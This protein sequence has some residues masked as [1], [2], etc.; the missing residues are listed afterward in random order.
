MLDCQNKTL[1]LI[2]FEFCFRVDELYKFLQLWVPHLYGELCPDEVKA[3]G[4]ELVES[5][6]ELWDDD[7][8]TAHEGRHPSQDGEISELTRE[9]W[10]VKIN[11]I[12]LHHS[13]QFT[14]SPD[15]IYI[16]SFILF[17]LSLECSVMI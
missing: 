8:S 3:K 12:C 13:V 2:N 7:P 11:L 10:E 17:S 14:N 15:F 9:S 4:F 16:L 5:D 6:T 1:S